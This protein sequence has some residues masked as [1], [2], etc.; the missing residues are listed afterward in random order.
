[1][2]FKRT[3]EDFDCEQCGAA[4]VGDGYTNHC[5]VCLYSKHVDVAPGDREAS[6]GGLMPPVGAEVRGDRVT[7]L[8]RCL[9]CGHESRCRTSE[10]DDWDAVVA[11]SSRPAVEP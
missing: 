3:V 5:R 4:N 10:V 9:V 2:S 1:M 6:C 11:V 8:H 7:L